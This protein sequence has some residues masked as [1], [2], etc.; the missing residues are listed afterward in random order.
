MYR[1]GELDASSANLV[2]VIDYFDALIRHGADTAAMMRASAALA[3]CVVGMDVTGWPGAGREPRR[4][5]TR[6]KWSPQPQLAP[7]SIKD[8]VID[9]AVVGN[10][11]I[12][13]PGPTL[14]LDDMLVD[15][16]ALTA[17]ILLQPRR[18][19]T[20][21]EHTVNLLFPMDDLAVLT[22][23]AGLG[24]DPDATVRIVVYATDAELSCPS[25]AIAGKALPITV[26]D[27]VLLPVTDHSSI[28]TRVAH[29]GISLPAAASKAHRYLGTARFARSHAS[30]SVPIVDAVE[31]GALNLLAAD[32]N[33][34]HEAIPD[35]V[36]ART[37][38]ETEFGSELV[39]TLR[40]YLQ[41][42]TLRTAADRMHLHHSSVAH[43][44]TK[45]SQ[46]FGFS[47]DSIENRARATAMMMVL[48]STA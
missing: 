27:E 9:D 42:G 35:L 16:M 44:L 21:A 6:G 29:V 37:L 17:A 38:G 46:H 15:R 28:T 1:L 4:C 2:R 40:I 33:L 36:R 18:A 45:L 26:D 7:S 5:D 31:L 25:D 12:E 39:A 47:V 3:D 24:I 43:R 11:W 23:C 19:L 10:V 14:P 22:S 8:V 41:S 48:D 34:P 32:H 20:P 30:D 13:R